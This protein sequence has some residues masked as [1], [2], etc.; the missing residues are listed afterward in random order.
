M[1]GM[2]MIN[3]MLI[4]LAPGTL[5]TGSCPPRSDQG[6]SN[7]NR[8]RLTF[9]APTEAELEIAA[10]ICKLI[11]SIEQVRLVSSGLKLV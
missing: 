2:S 1:L 3:P 4:M 8:K 10:L 11:P 5:N 7:H 9:G 6:R